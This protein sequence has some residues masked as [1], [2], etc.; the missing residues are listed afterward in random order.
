MHSANFELKKFR[1]YTEDLYFSSGPLAPSVTRAGILVSATQRDKLVYRESLVHQTSK[2]KTEEF[3]VL[4]TEDKS[5]RNA[6]RYKVQRRTVAIP[7][8][9][10]LCKKDGGMLPRNEFYI[11]APPRKNK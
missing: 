10:S 2:K 8:E 11:I 9:N 7:R 3:A 4:Q 5:M 1:I 6:A